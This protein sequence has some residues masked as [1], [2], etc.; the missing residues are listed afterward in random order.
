MLH[1]D[2]TKQQVSANSKKILK[3]GH[4]IRDYCGCGLCPSS[5][6]LCEHNV[7]ELI[8]FGPQVKGWGSAYTFWSVAHGPL[9]GISSFQRTQL[10]RCLRTLPP[11]D[12]NRSSFRNAVFFH[13]T[14][15]WT[16]FRNSVS[17][18]PGITSRRGIELDSQ[19]TGMSWG[20]KHITPDL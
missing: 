3:M 5:R 10:R 9:I 7:S 8:Y 17:R 20:R 12:G 6:I 19:L 4:C 2:E 16:K 15:R 18:K 1:M 11:E 13:N 14:R